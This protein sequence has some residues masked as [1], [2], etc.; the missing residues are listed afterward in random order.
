M[1]AM[2]GKRLLASV[3]ALILMGGPLHSQ[4]SSQDCAIVA[5]ELSERLRSH[6]LPYRAVGLKLK[7]QETGLATQGHVVVVW[8]PFKGGPYYMS[9]RSGATFLLNGGA[10]WPEVCAALVDLV[11]NKTKY[12]VTEIVILW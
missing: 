10:T 3:A 5:A 11:H 1:N 8:E 4:V 6:G 2:F 12:E 9:D 7:S